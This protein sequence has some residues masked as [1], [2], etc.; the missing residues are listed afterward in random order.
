MIS[1]DDKL[2]VLGRI[3]ALLNGDGITWAVGASAMLYFN[4]IVQDFH[5]IDIMVATED[6]PRAKELLMTIGTLEPPNLLA[7]YATK[8]FY[9]FII[10]GVDVDVMG[11]FAIIQNGQTID[12]SLTAGQI[13][14]AVSVAGENVPL[15]SPA[16]WRGY[17][18][19]MGREQKVKLIDDALI[20]QTK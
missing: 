2:R 13:A 19:L 20:G 14:S 6:A 7:K 15:Q 18:A 16:L 3:A 9:E 12:C 8:H 1:T 4:G 10:D 11:G 5:D 17:Y